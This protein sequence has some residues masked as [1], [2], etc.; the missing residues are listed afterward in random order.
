MNKIKYAYLAGIIEGEGCIFISN[1]KNKNRKTNYNFSTLLSIEMGKSDIPKF[2][3]KTF[4]GNLKVRK[5]K[6]RNYFMY[7][8]YVSGIKM[9]NILKKV[10]PYLQQK[11]KE[12]KIYFKYAKT[13]KYPQGRKRLKN[14]IVKLRKKLI[15][16]LK[17]EKKYE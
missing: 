9:Y 13:L 3:Y 10:Y 14:N 11:K 5:R 6:D 1:S 12:A 16:K 7:I 17:K 8:W 4:G 15:I 2:I